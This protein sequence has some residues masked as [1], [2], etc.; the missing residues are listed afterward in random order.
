MGYETDYALAFTQVTNQSTVK[1]P[2]GG[3]VMISPTTRTINAY[4]NRPAKWTDPAVVS[5]CPFRVGNTPRPCTKVHWY[6]GNPLV[7]V[8]G[9]PGVTIGVVGMC[10]SAKGVP[11][12]PAVILSTI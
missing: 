1:C 12:G 8:D 7:P 6:I 3:H 5:G 11:Q 10:S 4:G 2:H 9:V